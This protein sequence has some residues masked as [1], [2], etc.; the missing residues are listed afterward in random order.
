MVYKIIKFEA[1]WCQPCQT[2][3]PVWEKLA[4]QTP[5]VEFEVVD[6]D[7]DP[8]TTNAYSVRSIPTIVFLEDGEVKETLVGLQSLDQLTKTAF[9]LRGSVR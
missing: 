3:K 4:A 9:K 5:G 8:D 7:L 6:I 1:S 2:M